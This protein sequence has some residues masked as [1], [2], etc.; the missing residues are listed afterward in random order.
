MKTT[1]KNN[2]ED[3][4]FDSVIL[5]AGYFNEGFVRDIWLRFLSDKLKFRER[6]IFAR[7]VIFCVWFK[8]KFL[9]S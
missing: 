2:I 7:F 5:K 8:Y 9:A 6:L 4:I 3:T 1:W